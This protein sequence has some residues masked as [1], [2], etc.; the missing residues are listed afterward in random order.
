MPFTFLF[1]PFHQKVAL[2]CSF[3]CWCLHFSSNV[4]RKGSQQTPKM[5]RVPRMNCK[6]GKSDMPGLTVSLCV[7]PFNPPLYFCLLYKCSRDCRR[8]CPQNNQVFFSFFYCYCDSVIPVTAANVS[9]ST[10]RCVCY[11]RVPILL[12]TCMCSLFS[13]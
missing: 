4:K 5:S 13:F 3:H 9:G 8:L 7:R 11:L 2:L 6:A 10:W 12:W 1:L